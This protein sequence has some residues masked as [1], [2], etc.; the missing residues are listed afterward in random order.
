MAYPHFEAG[1]ALLSGRSN[2][3][4]SPYDPDG[5]VDEIADIQGAQGLFDAVTKMH[6]EKLTLREIGKRY[7][8]TV[9]MPQIVGTPDQVADQME[10][11]L[12][13]TG[14][15]RFNITP[16]YTPSSFD[17]FVDLVVPILQKRGRHRKAYT[18]NIFRG[19]FLQAEC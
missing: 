13:E 1:L 16:T 18:R 6:H 19:N 12:D 3:D 14:G 15:D 5:P 10:Y 4:L 2:Y 7:G 17:E 8:A 11:I 9:A